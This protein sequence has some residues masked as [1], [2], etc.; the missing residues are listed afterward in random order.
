MA[1]KV[2]ACTIPSQSEAR[3]GREQVRAGWNNEGHRAIESKMRV[4]LA[5]DDGFGAGPDKSAVN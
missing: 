4:D 2:A 3:D 5:G 1:S